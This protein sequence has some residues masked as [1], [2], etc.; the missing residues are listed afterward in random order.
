MHVT[1]ELFIK[2]YDEEYG[3]F[4]YL[5]IDTTVGGRCWGGVRIMPELSEEEMMLIA[6]TMTLKYGFLGFGIGGAKAG[7]MVSEKATTEDKKKILFKFGQRIGAFIQGGIF[8]PGTDMNCSV[9]DLK[10]IYQGAQMNARFQKFKDISYVYTSWTVVESIK[11]AAEKLA[12]NLNGLTV[13]IQGFG[14]V[15][16]ECAKLLAEMGL[17]IIAVST[18]KGAIYNENGLNIE[19][20]MSLK[21]TFSDDFVNKANE[22]KIDRERLLYIN[23]DVLIPAATSLS[24]NSEN[25]QKVNAKIISCAANAPM[26]DEIYEKLHKKGIVVIPDAVANCGGSFG[27]SLERSVGYDKIY[28]IIQEDYSQVIK[29]L[30]EK[31]LR[32]GISLRRLS[33]EIVMKRFTDS[34]RRIENSMKNKVIHFTNTN[35]TRVLHKIRN[36]KYN[37]NIFGELLK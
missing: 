31:S 34:K 11:A 4:G 22:K 10:S 16:S 24:I 25:F 15:G 21:D 14:K 5:V 8:M 18:V 17:K 23:T 36:Q 29:R 32:T 9:E 3:L 2:V 1:P 26:T 7:V 6:R 27:S 19:M 30:I 35:I 33:L 37:V 28:R 12:L 20:V 13:A